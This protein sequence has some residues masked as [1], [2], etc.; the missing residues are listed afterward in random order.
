M[1]RPGARQHI[2]ERQTHRSLCWRARGIAQPFIWERL[3][4]PEIPEDNTA[5]RARHR[6]EWC[7]DATLGRNIADRLEAILGRPF[8]T[9]ELRCGRWCP[10][11][12]AADV[13]STSDR[14]G[15]FTVPPDL[16]PIP[17]HDEHFDRPWRIEVA[18]HPAEPPPGP[19]VD[20]TSTSPE[21][22]EIPETR[23]WF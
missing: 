7:D 6:R 15:A 22:P 11:T 18:R 23:I 21:E 19:Q 3:E 12:V 17:D 9:L 2:L 14:D 10:V 16:E 20:V 8:L 13:E 1:G 5:R 4:E